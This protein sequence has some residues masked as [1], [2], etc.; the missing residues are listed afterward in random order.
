MCSY[1]NLLAAHYKARKGKTTKPDVQEFEKNLHQNLH[2]LQTELLL[3]SYRPQPLQT[4]ILR[5]PKTRKIGKSAYRD[6]VIH[7]ALVRVIEPFFEPGFLHCSFAN[8]K[9]KGQ[10]AAVE[11]F[12]RCSKKVS[13]NWTRPC[14]VLKADIAHYF[15]EVHHSILLQLL[16]R[17]IQDPVVRWL[18]KIILQNHHG[19]NPDQG[20]PLGNLTSQF[21]ANV[22]LHEL[23]RFVKHTLKA[24]HYIRYV[25][26][27]V[28]LHQDQQQLEHWR[29]MIGAF[30]SK[31]LALRLHP[32]KQQIREMREGISFLGFRVFPHHRLLRKSNMQTW[33]WRLRGMVTACQSG[34]IPYDVLFASL[35]GWIAYARNA[36]TFKLRRHTTK[37]IER[38]FPKAISSTEVD[39]WL[40][41]Y[42]TT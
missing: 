6:R 20:M 31:I 3:R 32:Q 33:K 41:A 39:R 9:G 35:N 13:K 5:D 2:L 11:Y 10:I 30:L 27:F 8:R 22:Y 26:D 19:Q 7:H 1:G 36:D 23:D 21:F 40:K 12:E 14:Y 24:K 28:I 18:I 37:I 34:E 16:Q 29:S 4:F 17:R 25:D 15:P 42:R 38:A